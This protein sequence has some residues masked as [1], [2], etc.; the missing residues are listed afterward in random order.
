MQGIVANSLPPDSKPA[1]MRPDPLSLR[2]AARRYSSRQLP[3][4]TQS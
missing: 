1:Q 3:K 4:P 2:L